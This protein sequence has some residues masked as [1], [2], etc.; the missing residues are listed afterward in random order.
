[1]IALHQFGILKTFFRI[2]PAK[3]SDVDMTKHLPQ[4][5]KDKIEYARFLGIDV[6]SWKKVLLLV[7][8]SAMISLVESYYGTV[9]WDTIKKFLNQN[10]DGLNGGGIPTSRGAATV[11]EIF[12]EPG[13]A[14]MG[15]LKFFLSSTFEFQFILPSILSKMLIDVPY[16]L[17]KISKRK[18]AL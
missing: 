5:H 1:M 4:G 14:F 17:S 12:N 7:A 9:E 3:K 10:K 8:I 15:I 11:I 18:F 6:D 2:G 13:F 16:E